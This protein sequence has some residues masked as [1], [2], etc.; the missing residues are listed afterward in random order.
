MAKEGEMV[1]T[2][3]KSEAL[4]AI[5]TGEVPGLE[6]EVGDDLCDC[7]FQRIGYWTNPYMGQTLRVR[8]CCLWKELSKDYPD[9]VQEVPFFFNENTHQ[10]ESAPHD[11]NGEFDMPRAVWYRQLATKLGLSLPEVREQYRD[12]EP[13][14]GVPKPKIQPR[15]RTWRLR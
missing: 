11:W 10:Y 7:I 1:K 5:L 4:R 15:R 13:P 8:L 12:Q 6:W 9:F 2:E 14:K 3:V